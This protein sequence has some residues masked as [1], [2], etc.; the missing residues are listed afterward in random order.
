MPD[1]PKKAVDL[2]NTVANNASR[3]AWTRLEL[4]SHQGSLQ[5]AKMDNDGRIWTNLILLRIRRLGFES[6]RARPGQRPVPILG[7]AFR[8]PRTAAL[9]ATA[10]HERASSAW[11]SSWSSQSLSCRSASLV[12]LSGTWV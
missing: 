2:A 3:Q 4:P 10:V 7:P 11:S 5:Q 8:M 9:T 6:L 12:T 1:R